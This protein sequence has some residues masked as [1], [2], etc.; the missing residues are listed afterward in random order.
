MPELP[1]ITI[2]IEALQ[3]RII[4]EVI[5]SAR[6]ENPFL[7]RTVE[8]PFDA[9]EG[10]AV[11][12]LRRIGKRVVWQLQDDLFLVFHLMISGRFRWS[13]KFNAKP[14]GKIRLASFRF[15]RGSLSVTEAASRKRASLHLVD[16]AQ[17]LSQFDSGGVEVLDASFEDFREALLRERH[18][19]KRALTDPRLF[20]GIGNAYSD[21]ILHARVAETCKPT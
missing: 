20:S 12:A 1:D 4:G 9:V 11:I 10:R 13:H 17:A 3:E 19:V 8:P 18:T 21:E 7:L 5:Q 2:Y 14:A 15:S 16:G 6:I